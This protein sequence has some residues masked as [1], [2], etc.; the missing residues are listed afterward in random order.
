MREHLELYNMVEDYVPV[1][2]VNHAYSIDNVSAT[3]RQMRSRGDR[4]NGPRYTSE[5]ARQEKRNR[6]KRFDLQK[7]FK[8]YVYC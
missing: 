8:A 6:S 5:R 2:Q 3:S 1:T 7:P 4:S